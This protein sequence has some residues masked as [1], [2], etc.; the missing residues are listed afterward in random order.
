MILGARL[1]LLVVIVDCF[2]YFG[3]GAVGLYPGFGNQIG[4]LV[5][6]NGTVNGSNV[7]SLVNYSSGGTMVQ[8]STLG[9]TTTGIPSILGFAG[10]IY[11]IMTV[12]L[13]MVALFCA[14]GVCT[15]AMIF[16]QVLVGGVY[17][18]LVLAS[19]AQLLTGRFA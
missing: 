7:N 17:I 18:V 16:V 19:I 15:G 11:S 3:M 10:M 5:Q 9:Y 14:G 8:A 12:P 13:N 2:L 4:Q 6:L 1:L